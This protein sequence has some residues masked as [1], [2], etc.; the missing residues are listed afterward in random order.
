[1][2]NSNRMFLKNNLKKDIAKDKKEYEYYLCKNIES[3][4]ISI[5]NDYFQVRNK[6]LDISLKFLKNG[7]V[8]L[9]I[10]CLIDNIS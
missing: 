8:S 5:L 3:I 2:Q 1:M 7:D 9:N 10:N 4:L 6:T